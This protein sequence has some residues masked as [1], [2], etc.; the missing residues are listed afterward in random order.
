MGREGGCSHGEIKRLRP[1]FAWKKI[2]VASVYLETPWIQMVHCHFPSA[3]VHFV[4]SPGFEKM[5][6]R[7]IYV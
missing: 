3:G 1:T 6:Y 5:K 7:C 2:T 4:S